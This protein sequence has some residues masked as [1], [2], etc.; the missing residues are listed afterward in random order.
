MSLLLTARFADTVAQLPQ[1][2]RA[3]PE[4]LPEVAFVG[5]SNAGKSSCINTVC[6]QKRLAF[7]SRTPGRTQALNLF[8][9][10]P[11]NQPRPTGFLVDTPGYGFATASPQA[12]QSWQRLA[13]DYITRRQALAGVVLMVDIRRGLTD[14]DRQLL[15]WTPAVLPLV[16][17]LTKA[18]KLSRQQAVKVR[19]Q[20]A[21]EPVL[22]EREGPVLLQLFSIL[23][24]H[25]VEALRAAIGHLLQDGPWH[26]QAL[27]AA[28]GP[29]M[30]LLLKGQGLMPDA[31]AQVQ[32][33]TAT[34]APSGPDD[35]VAAEQGPAHPDHRG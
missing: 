24:R 13:G 8:A 1:L 19:D 22:R 31:Q 35:E 12:K 20:I 4:G 17:V 33:Q 27:V 5:R 9:V 26:W 11:V 28:R 29:A 25:G 34:V 21:R 15:A 23:N 14:L 3:N 16:L 2:D 10:G 30:P 32:A 6:N 18:D 7:S